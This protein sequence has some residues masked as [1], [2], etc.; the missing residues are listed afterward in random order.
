MCVSCFSLANPSSSF[1]G[2][3]VYCPCMS[4]VKKIKILWHANHQSYDMFGG[5]QPHFIALIFC[6]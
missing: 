1:Y 5:A 4:W 3:V 2:F 6:L